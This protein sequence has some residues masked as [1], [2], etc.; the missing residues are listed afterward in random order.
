M[1]NT[2]SQGTVSRLGGYPLLEKIGSGGLGTVYKSQDPASGE[3]VALKVVSPAVLADPVLRMRFAQEC[4]VASK[5]DHPHAVKFLSFGMDGNKPFLVMEYVDGVS[6]GERLQKEGRL[7]EEEAVRLTVQV[8]RAL[9]HAH[10]RR[11]IHRDVKP[12]NVLVNRQGDAKLVD[13]G[14][15]KSLDSDLNLTVTAS[16]LGTPNFMAPEQFED[17][18]R[19]DERSDLYSLAATLYAL[20]CGELPFHANTRAVATMYKKKLANEIAP[21]RQLVPE[22]SERL[23]AAVLRAL[24]ADRAERQASVV[25]FIESLVAP[26]EAPAPAREARAK[27]RVA[28]HSCTVCQPLQRSPDKGWKGKVINL[29][30]GGLCL[31]LGRRF[32]PGALLTVVLEGSKAVRR[33]LVARVVWV[34][35][36]APKQWRMGCRF[37]QPLS[38]PEVDE[39]A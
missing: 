21:P 6:L 26:A 25:E 35:K 8:G 4:Q 17:A 16:G 29:S 10:Q 11:I 19:A 3:P 9:D 39:L 2:A 13:L 27:K 7:S 28:A 36:D 1:A 23:E 14:L 38:E 18:K 31:M 20:V 5:L 22:L 30:E 34:K 12:D 24:R 32:E 15:G 33:S 37:D